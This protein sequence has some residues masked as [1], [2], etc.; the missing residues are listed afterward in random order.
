MEVNNREKQP[1]SFGCVLLE[2][3]PFIEGSK[4]IAQVR[5]SSWL[6]SRKYNGLLGWGFGA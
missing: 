5:N 2:F 6:D 4:V 1:G 3:H